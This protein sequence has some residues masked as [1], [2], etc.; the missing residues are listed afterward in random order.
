M[1]TRENCLESWDLGIIDKLFLVILCPQKSKI[2]MKQLA[3][4]TLLFLFTCSIS[5]AQ[6]VNSTTVYPKIVGYSSILFPIVVLDKNAAVI[7]FNDS[8]TVGFPVGI[9]ILK[10]DKIGFSFEIVPLIKVEDGKD[11]MSNLLFHPGIMFRYKNGFTF[12]SRVAFETSGRY[13][14]TPVFNK[15]LIKGKNINFMTAVSLPMRFGNEK[16]PSIG[17][18]IQFGIAF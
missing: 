2:R 7:N 4:I 17:I 8:Y 6:Q 12:I 5:P 15:R 13:G 10:S 3:V 16:P 14:I 9:N 1:F 11:K 18:A